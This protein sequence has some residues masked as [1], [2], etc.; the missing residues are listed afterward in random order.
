MTPEL[1]VVLQRLTRWRA[2]FAGWQLGTR[3][4]TD[5]E[6]RAIR[7]HRE[8]TMLMR[9]EL[10]ALVLMLIQK[11]VFTEAEYDEAYRVE[12]EF[13]EKSFER[14]FPGIK[15]TDEGIV[16]TPEAVETMRGWKP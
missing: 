3:P 7:D 5:P 9:A 12:A 15:A 6:T 14:R 4:L 8:V 16:M 10:S 11:G 13:L 2:V 1:Q